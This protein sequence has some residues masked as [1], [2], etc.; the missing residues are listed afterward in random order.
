MAELS[1]KVEGFDVSARALVTALI[2]NYNY[3]RFLAEAVDS[4]LSQ[5]WENIEV[6]VVDDGSTDNSREVL[7]RYGDRIRVIQKENDGQASAFN[8]GIAAARGEIIC[9][10]DSDDTWS[11]DK[12]SKVVEKYRE[13]PWGLVCHD[14]ELMD[15]EGA[16]I[17]GRGWCDYESVTL[18]Q[19][20]IFGAVVRGGYPWVFSPTSGMSLPTS[21]A[22]TLLPLPEKQWRICAD[23]PLAYAAMCHAPV[24]VLSGQ[25]GRYRLHGANGFGSVN[26]DPILGRIVG[27]VHPARCYLYLRDYLSRIGRSLEISPLDNYKYRRRF[28]M[29]ATDRPWQVLPELWRHNLKSV[30]K[31]WGNI[32]FLILDPLLAAAIALRMPTAHREIRERFL[33][34]SSKVEPKA[35]AYLKGEYEDGGP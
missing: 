10:L 13:G 29:I 27:V 22:R 19:G 20:D 30:S 34:Y 23:T 2:C 7:A 15:G 31:N 16:D 21:L 26:D 11:S 28:R 5:T 33:E 25:W 14:L 24:G 12:V 9:F 1:D 32:R 4:A 35:L 18:S 8:V 3:G 6:I 17:D